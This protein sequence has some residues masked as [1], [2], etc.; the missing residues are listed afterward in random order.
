MVLLTF[1]W[2]NCVPDCRRA[3]SRNQVPKCDWARVSECTKVGEEVFGEA[4]LL[5]ES[6]K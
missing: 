2:I 5:E 1:T 4:Y 6:D 3:N